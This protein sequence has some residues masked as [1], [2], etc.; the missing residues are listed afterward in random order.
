MLDV[1]NQRSSHTSPTPRGGGAA[2]AGFVLLCTALT[3][4]IG[5]LPLR[6]AIALFGGGALV[7]GIGWLDDRHSVRA[8]LRAAA[9]LC[10]AA[11][12]IYWMGGVGGTPLGRLGP[13]A[14][15][16]EIAL[17]ILAIAWMINLYNFMDGIDGIAA[18]EAIF[19]GGAGAI[20]LL[21]GGAPG[22]AIISASIAGSAAGFFIWNRMPARIFM[23]DV[24]SGF[25]GFTFATIALSAHVTATV[26]VAVWM[27]LLLVFLTDA[28]ITLIRRILHG[29]TW[30][31]AHRLHA[32]Q[33]L[34]QSGLSHA[35]VVAWVA[36]LNA[37]LALLAVGAF[38]RPGLQWQSTLIGILL[39]VA[40]Y[41]A[42]E[43]RLGM[44]APQ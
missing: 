36:L 16:L 26:P 8:S 12:A 7:A 23:G 1:P 13:I 21:L 37:L 20:F 10:A 9:H 30:H 29:E 35:R 39:T 33:R 17:A 31:Q 3:A 22:L 11:W 4:T 32:Y 6:T 24:G 14:A 2:I 40:A 42:V 19:V 5:W 28:T 34:V 44:W 25:L 18:V 38:L 15:S 27:L 41:C 43:R